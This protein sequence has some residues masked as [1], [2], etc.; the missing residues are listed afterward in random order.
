MNE[1][2]Q[3]SYYAIIPATVRY[4][5]ELKPAEKLLYGEITA[6]SNKYGYCYAQNRYF[7]K[8][9]GV[10]LETVSR[11][12]SN[13]ERLGYIKRNIIRNDKKEVLVRY[14][15]IIDVPH[16]IRSIDPIDKK[17]NTPYCEKSQYPIDEKVKGN[18][19]NNN[20][21][22]DDLYYYIINDTFKIP[23]DFYAIIKKLE[24]VYTDEMLSI[25]QL[26]NIQ[27]IKEIVFVLY[28]LYNTGFDFL[29]LKLSRESLLNLYKKAKNNN[30]KNLLNYYKQSIINKYNNSS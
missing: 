27:M 30:P 8:L 14:I 21:M 22:I 11:W 15:Y 17:I 5:K 7:A 26:E 20:N 16:F 10:S 29:L 4:N 19:I 28:D 12:M 3:I 25:M 2:N 18:I 1:E 13:L 23:K 9:Y 24:F 6:L